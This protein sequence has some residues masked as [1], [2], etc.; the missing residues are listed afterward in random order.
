MITSVSCAVSVLFLT[1]IF[2]EVLVIDHVLSVFFSIEI[3]IIWAFFVL[4]NKVFD[5]RIKKYSMLNRFLRY[6][7]VSLSGLVLNVS[8]FSLFFIWLNLF[9]LIS[10]FIAMI[11]TAGFNLYM[12][13]NFAWVKKSIN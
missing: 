11:F 2:T 7:F 6:Q 5:Q 3:T 1:F 4:D 9:Y 10:E 12:V 8:L 13:R